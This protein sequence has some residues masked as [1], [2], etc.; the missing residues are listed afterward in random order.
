MLLK[1][2]EGLN[3]EVIYLLDDLASEL[4]RDSRERVCK[5]LVE[6]GNQILATGVDQAELASCWGAITKTM[7]HVEHGVIKRGSL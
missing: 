7:F 1:Q 3:G 6:K 4:D 2:G 5:Y